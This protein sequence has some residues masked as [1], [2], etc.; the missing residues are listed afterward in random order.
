MVKLALNWL[1]NLT[2][3]LDVC[4]NLR[5]SK[6][7]VCGNCETESGGIWRPFV[8]DVTVGGVFITQA[9]IYNLSNEDK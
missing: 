8:T 9:V 1:L 7:V 6:K 2:R 3:P 5:L 4:K